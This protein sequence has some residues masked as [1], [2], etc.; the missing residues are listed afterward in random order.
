MFLE[1]GWKGK[2]TLFIEVGSMKVLNWLENKAVRPWL[3]FPLF[4]EVDLRL[5]LMG[6]VTFLLTD[7]SGNKLAF[8]LVVA[9][10]KRQDM[11]KASWR[12]KGFSGWVLA[13]IFASCVVVSGPNCVD[14]FILCGLFY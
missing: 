10:V 1:L 8:V 4:K 2:C 12:L 5:S 3:L 6:I 7:K 9:G 11:F 13:V 14:L